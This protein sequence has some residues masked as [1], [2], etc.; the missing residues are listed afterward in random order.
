MRISGRLGV[1][2]HPE[3]ARAIDGV[4]GPNGYSC[5]ATARAAGA[6]AAAP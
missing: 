5:S 1:S 3:D 4:A 6:H 2:G